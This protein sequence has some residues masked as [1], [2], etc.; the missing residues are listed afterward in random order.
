M[1][2][3]RVTRVILFVAFAIGFAYFGSLY[4]IPPGFLERGT[5]VADGYE[6]IDAGGYEQSIVYT[7]K[8]RQE[9]VVIDA[10]VDEFKVDGDR[11]L[12]AR[13][14]RISKLAA[15]GALDSALQTSCEYWSIDLRTHKIEEVKESTVVK[16]Y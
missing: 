12:V 5:P 15:D 2:I 9:G 4:L 16:C 14:P 7:G 13:R 1:F 11:L 10:R 3:K 8:H 6:L